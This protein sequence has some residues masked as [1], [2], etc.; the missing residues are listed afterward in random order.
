L[1]CLQEEEQ[2]NISNGAGRELISRLVY[3]ASQDNE[4]I[5]TKERR[6]IETV[7]VT[8][9]LSSLDVDKIIAESEKK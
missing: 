7:A 1:Y 6:M 9:G 4:Q 3:I 8:Y 5:T 2:K